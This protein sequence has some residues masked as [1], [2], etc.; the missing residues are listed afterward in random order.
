MREPRRGNCERKN[1]YFCLPESHSLADECQPAVGRLVA[2]L[3]AECQGCHRLEQAEPG[4]IAE[5]L[6]VRRRRFFPRIFFRAFFARQ[7]LLA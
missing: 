7:F 3:C 1:P 4:L 5:V 2:E 6:R